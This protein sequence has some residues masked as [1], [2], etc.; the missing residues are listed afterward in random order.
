MSEFPYPAFFAVLVRPTSKVSW[1]I[2]CRPYLYT[3]TDEHDFLL[4]WSKNHIFVIVWTRF[5]WW[6]WR[7]L[8]LPQPLIPIP[9]VNI[10]TG[11]ESPTVDANGGAYDFSTK[12]LHL[13]WHPT[14]NAL[15]CAAANSLYMYYAED[16]TQNDTAQN[17]QWKLDLAVGY[18][19]RVAVA[20]GP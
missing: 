1:I 14:S 18:N 19:I 3:N 7:F 16:G 11:G 4:I 5:W 2:G 20:I 12:L 8:S 6:L 15:A 17:A 13:A 10:F 9:N